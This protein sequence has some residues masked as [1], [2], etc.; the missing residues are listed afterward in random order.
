M[1]VDAQARAGLSVTAPDRPRIGMLWGDFPWA[2]PPPK[3][4]QLWSSGVV[5]R[6]VTRALNALGQVVPFT[7]SQGQASPQ[8]QRRRLTDF[9][10]SIDLLWA[11]LY[12]GSADVLQLRHDLGLDCPAL[13]YAGG[14]MPKAAEAMLFPW[15][16]L[17]TSPVCRDGSFTDYD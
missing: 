1:H 6:N 9:L 15:Q 14:V 3:V 5:A 11:D 16:H 8:L 17:L 7:S 10:L 12:P 13:L 4:G 2:A